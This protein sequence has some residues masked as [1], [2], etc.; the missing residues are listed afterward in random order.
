[1]KL[2]YIFIY[3]T[4]EDEI[5]RMAEDRALWRATRDIAVIHTA[6]P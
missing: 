1:M 6:A 5:K 2:P 4:D 3:G